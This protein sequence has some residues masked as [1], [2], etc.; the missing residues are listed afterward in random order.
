M[1]FEN[2]QGRRFSYSRGAS[3]MQTSYKSASTSKWVTAA[4]ILRAV[5]Q[6]LVVD[7]KTFSLDSL[8]SEWIT[9]WPIGNLEIADISLRDLLSFTSGLTETP[10]CISI[11]TVLS[12]EGCVARIAN[13]NASNDKVPGAEFY[14]GGNHMQAAGL[15]TMK[16]LGQSSWQG[17]FDAFQQETGLFATS[18]YDLPAA[19]SGPRL[20]GGMHW[21]GDEYLA[22]VR[23]MW[24]GELL[25]TAMQS[26]MFSDQIASA[27]IG[28]S[29]SVTGLQE[30]WHYGYG[31]WIECPNA[32]YNCTAITR[33]SSAGAFGAYP[34]IDVEYGYIGIVAREGGLGTFTQG[35]EIARTLAGTLAQWA[36]CPA[37]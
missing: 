18:A 2:A 12:F 13:N 22:F 35:I 10:L 33:L 21:T 27:T 16:A 30:D 3:T 31:G 25:S 5:E 17:V 11:G 8:A 23:A 26:A 1:S 36:S 20:A 4:I 7:D 29:P 14:Y 19:A 24:K 37:S 34:F 32:T 6:N 28:S 15:M 9:D